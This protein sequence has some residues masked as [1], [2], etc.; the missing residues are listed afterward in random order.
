MPV[1]ISG[2]RLSYQKSPEAWLKILPG[3]I[4]ISLIVAY[5]STFF[6]SHSPYNNS[7]FG[8]FIFLMI[9]FIL[10]SFVMLPKTKGYLSIDYDDETL[11]YRVNQKRGDFRLSEIDRF[12]LSGNVL[13]IY[14][15]DK[16]KPSLEVLILSE[17]G[18]NDKIRQ[19]FKDVF[20]FRA[21]QVHFK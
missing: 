2:N 14:L 15:R 13:K 21:S 1:T 10:V 3:F 5:A 18:D 6:V 11:H 16:R 4:I 7:V 8:V 20:A 9:A 12:S 17:P 19:F